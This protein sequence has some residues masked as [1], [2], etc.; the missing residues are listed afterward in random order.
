MRRTLPVVIVSLSLAAIAGC[1]TSEAATTQPGS[2][3]MRLP[4]KGGAQP[5]TAPAKTP[6]GA[7]PRLVFFKNPD[8]VP[9][10]MQQRVLDEMRPELS[11]K[12]E[13][14]EYR[15]T[16]RND[17]AKFEQ[18]GI[19]SL[20]ALVLTDASGKEIRR[21]TP[22]IQQASAIRKLVTP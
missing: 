22:G 2:D 8:G 4:D 1:S 14:V 7:V 11:G 18:F 5:A 21:A 9:C 17:L 13:L 20:P 16:S 10:Q 3:P 12:V 15:T 19:R 6:D